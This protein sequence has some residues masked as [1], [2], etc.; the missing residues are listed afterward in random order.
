[1][2]N[3]LLMFARMKRTSKS[4]NLPRWRVARIASKGQEICQLR[5]KT[6]DEAKKRAIREFSIEERWQKRLLVYRVG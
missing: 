6:A 5:A 4:E 3:D 2:A 1:M